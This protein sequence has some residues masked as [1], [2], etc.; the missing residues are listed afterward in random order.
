MKNVLEELY[1]QYNQF[2]PD[3]EILQEIESSH[4]QLI[5]TLEKPERSLVLCIIDNKDLIAGARA[6]ESFTCGFW[7]AWRLF[8]QLHIFDGSHSLEDNLNMSGCFIV[9]K[10]EA[11]HDEQT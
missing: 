2:V 11:E 5:D 9:K 10:G 8:S 4:R 6:K 1:N 7:L 3:A